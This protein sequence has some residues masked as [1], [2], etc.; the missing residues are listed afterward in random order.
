MP[1]PTSE[2]ANHVTAWQA[3]GLS[4]ADYCRQVGLP[5]HRFRFMLER[6]SA[7]PLPSAGFIEVRRPSGGSEAVLELPGQMRLRIPV[8]ADPAWVGHIIRS[9][10]VATSC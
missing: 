10:L 5:Y 3:S 9:L 8:S 1:N 7:L 2:P 6:R 4:Q